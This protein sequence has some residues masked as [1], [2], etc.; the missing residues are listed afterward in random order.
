MMCMC[1]TNSDWVFL[2]FD[3]MGRDELYEILDLLVLPC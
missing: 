3:C 2:G 1:L